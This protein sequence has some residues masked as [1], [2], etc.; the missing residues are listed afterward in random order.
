[1]PSDCDLSA[2]EDDL[3][4]RQYATTVWEGA[5]FEE[6][7][8]GEGRGGDGAYLEG[9]RESSATIC[10]WTFVTVTVTVV[11]TAMQAIGGSC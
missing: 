8:R 10:R 11:E 2:V 6:G 9:P 3:D 4:C 5:I 7:R 1:M